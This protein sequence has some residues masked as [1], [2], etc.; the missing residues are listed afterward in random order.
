MVMQKKK[1]ELSKKYYGYGNGLV[2]I[3]R[4]DIPLL[5]NL[6]SYLYFE[7]T[8]IVYTLYSKSYLH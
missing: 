8:Y 4:E 2:I 3:H 6:N 1:K 7:Y 5:R